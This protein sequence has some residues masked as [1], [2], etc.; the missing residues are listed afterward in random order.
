MMSPST[1]PSRS[2]EVWLEDRVEL[3]G[4][5]LPQCARSSAASANWRDVSVAVAVE[6][7]ERRSWP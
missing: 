3:G 4:G 1:S 7:M 2:S 6:L 5:D